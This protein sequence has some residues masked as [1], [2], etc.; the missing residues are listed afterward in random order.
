MTPWTTLWVRR[1]RSSLTT[2]FR[3]PDSTSG[4][5][6]AEFALGL[7]ILFGAVFGIIELGR[8]GYTHAA[9]YHA[10]QETTRWAIVNPINLA[11]GET[12]AEYE[13]RLS[14]EAQSNLILISAG[15]V[16]TVTASAPESGQN[17]K[18]RNIS[19]AI[20]FQYEPLMPYVISGPIV[21]TTASQAFIADEDGRG[22]LVG[23]A[24]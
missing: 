5:T 3:E 12:Q 20:S 9:L 8:F 24:D 19:I 14:A 13:A 7:P 17:D 16:A 23:A 11:G 10:A 22:S 6:V 2:L 21:V 18:T 1:C 4:A 15:N